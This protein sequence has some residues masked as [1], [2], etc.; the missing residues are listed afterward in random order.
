[1]ARLA[2][3]ISRESLSEV[4]GLTHRWSWRIGTADAKTLSEAAGVT[5]LLGRVLAAR[6]VASGEEAKA[7]IEPSLSK[8]LHEPSLLPDLDRAAERIL[9]AVKEREPIVIFGDYDAD[10]LCAT[11]ILVR[12][13][14]TIDPQALVTP[15]IPSRIDEGYGLS[16]EAI[17]SLA[18]NGAKVIVSVDCGI[19]AFEQADISL[20]NG[21]D[22]IITDHHNPP[23]E[24][25]GIPNAY[26]VVHPRR[27]GSLYPFGELCGAG[28][29]FK[30]AWRI[31]TMRAGTNAV[32]KQ[33]RATLLELMS[34]AAI[35]TVADIVPLVDENRAIVRF[36]L[37]HLPSSKS[38]GVRALLAISDL[39]DSAVTSEDAG[40]RLAPRLN[41]AGR[42][43]HANLAL[44]L[45]LTNDATRAG[46][47]AREL[48][49]LNT[50]RKAEERRIAEEASGMVDEEMLTSDASRTIVLAS[51]DWNPGIV[52]I[53]CSRLVRKF[54]RP[55]ILLCEQNGVLSGSG[56]SI[57]GYSLHEGL[58]AA[59]EHLE[60]FG[61]HDMAA[62]LSLRA[63]HLEAFRNELERHAAHHIDEDMLVPMLR[64]DASARPNE[65]T[66]RSIR[67]LL[68]LGPFGA[69]NRSPRIMLEGIKLGRGAEALG[70]HGNHIAL[71]CVENGVGIRV[72]GWGFGEFRELLRAGGVVDLVVEPKINEWQGRLSVEGT[73]IDARLH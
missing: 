66:V 20:A 54:G 62:G 47:I 42:M 19:T 9:S 50:A 68:S 41:A 18:Q 36:G 8:A 10:G 2:Q 33:M 49:D 1:M 69:G 67:E 23:D 6:G 7:L 14:K 13:I 55:T 11:A 22:L 25:T 48:N 32:G 34:L 72:V 28:V 38:V 44:E 59:A 51:K 4:R 65:L 27:P 15:Y 61:G 17:T 52:G 21:V 29:A 70:A 63:E 46:A 56:R 60:R 58:T 3:P 31:A 12:L 57:D 24:S 71:H 40:Y 45:L 43:A 39:N 16:T 64:I 30:L 37:A 5:D 53:V 35:A 26:A 73:L